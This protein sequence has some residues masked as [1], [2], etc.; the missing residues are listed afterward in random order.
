LT[1]EEAKEAFKMCTRKEKRAAMHYLERVPNGLLILKGAAGCGKTFYLQQALIDAA[2]MV[3][4]T[5][6]RAASSFVRRFASQADVAACD[7]AGC[8]TEAEIL[9]IWKGEALILGG[10]PEQ[11]PPPVFTDSVKDSNG[12][13]VNAFTQQLGKPLMRRFLELNWPHIELNEQKR[14]P[15]GQ[16][17]LVNE[18]ISNTVTTAPLDMDL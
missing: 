9:I 7:E 11:L 6:T 13:H 16:F 14:M 12:T 8:A 2:D 15:P 4:C 18:V 10:D 3:F 17:D 1:D 5:T